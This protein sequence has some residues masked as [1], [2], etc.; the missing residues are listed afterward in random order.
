MRKLTVSFKKRNRGG[1]FVVI[2]RNIFWMWHGSAYIQNLE[3]GL[4]IRREVL[5]AAALLHDIGKAL[6]YKER[7]PHE[8][9]SAEIA[10]TILNDLG[11]EFSKE[12]KASILQAIRGHRSSRNGQT[13]SG[14]SAL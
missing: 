3:E 6:Q 12:E 9:A 7:I 5:Y 11:D 1:S 2:R 4:G 8:I 10:G 14:T 13:E